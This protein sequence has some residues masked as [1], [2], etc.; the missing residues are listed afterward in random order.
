MVVEKTS[1]AGGA[2][3]SVFSGEFTFVG[4]ERCRLDQFLALRQPET[5]RSRLQALVRAE[6]VLVNGVAAKASCLLKNGDCVSLRI[7]PPEPLELEP[8]ALPLEIIYEDRHLVVVNKAAGMVV[9][10]AAGNPDGTLVNALLY[11]C[12][13]LAGIGGVMR[14]G[15]V[16]RLDRDTSGLLVVAKDDLTHQGLARQFKLHSIKREYVALVYGRVLPLGGAFQSAIGRHPQQ[17]KKM[18][19]VTRGGKAARTNY[20]VLRHYLGGACSWL[21]LQLET[22]RTHQIRV[23]LSE[24]GYP[25]VGDQIYVKKGIRRGSSGFSGAIQLAEFPRQALHARSLGFIH[26]ATE[27][28]L[29]FASSLPAD[30]AGLLEA[31]SESEKQACRAT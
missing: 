12:G 14:P 22:G 17:R 31:L 19:S 15:I 2:E 8:Q 7:P 13:D 3:G 26:P 5:S 27:K 11:H 30:L 20:Q 25:L 10:P 28:Y 16:H 6:Q 4:A 1:A 21:S 18:A 9:H 29:D 24:A 23:H